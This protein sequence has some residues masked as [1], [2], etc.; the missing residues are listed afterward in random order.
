MAFAV[1]TTPLWQSGQ[2]WPLVLAVGVAGGSAMAVA[3]AAV[4]GVGAV[5][6]VA[7]ASIE[8]HDTPFASGQQLLSTLLGTTV[9]D[10]SGQRFGTVRDLVVDL[11]EGSDRPAVTH[12]LVSTKRRD[13]RVSS[14]KDVVAP[15]AGDGLMVR[16]SHLSA[17]PLS[18]PTVLFLRRDVLDSLVVTTEAPRRRRVAD[19]LVEVGP[20]GAH[21]TGVD[22]SPTGLAHRVLR[23]ASKLGD[24]PVLPLSG[25]HLVSGAG[26]TAQL[27]ARAPSV[28]GLPAGK[29]AEVL[30]LV[31]VSH[32]RDIMRAMDDD[33]RDHAVRLLH[34]HVRA[35][36]TGADGPV[37]RTR[38]LHGWRVHRSG[39]V[40][41]IDR[42]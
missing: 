2:S 27:A 26:H 11:G 32:A 5:R 33:V 40:P 22:L 19:V 15:R 41:P 31:P 6:L 23:R 3:M 25:V 9:Y 34:P 37:R 35:R 38:R 16:A 8:G 18:G 30:T 29:I 28:L 17:T 7:R 21:V 10:E 42:R 1:V 24:A 13:V 14:W 4:T 39:A 12:L 36:V 20:N